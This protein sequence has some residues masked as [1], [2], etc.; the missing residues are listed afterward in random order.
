MSVQEVSPQ[1][2]EAMLENGE[3]L[4]LLDCRE[5]QEYDIAS[6]KTAQLIPMSELG[7]RVHEIE[8]QQQSQ[9][10]VYCHH[11]VRSQ[12]VAHWLM[13]SGFT[14]VKSLAGGIDRWALEI[15]PSLPRY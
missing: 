3:A 13:Q 6:I 1:Q 8:S 12:R 10:I 11:G 4:F 15:E 2:L 9:V 5:Q 7:D 14:N